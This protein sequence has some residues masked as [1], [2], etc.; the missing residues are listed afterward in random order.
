MIGTGSRKGTWW[1]P[2]NTYTTLKSSVNYYTEIKRKISLSSIE[3]LTVSTDALSGEFV[4]H[5]PTEYDYLYSSSRRKEIITHIQLYY[6]TSKSASLP[7]YGVPQPHL[8]DYRTT[9]SDRKKGLSKIPSKAFLITNFG[10]YESSDSP[11]IS[12]QSIEKDMKA[13]QIKDAAIKLDNFNVLKLLGKGSFGY[14]NYQ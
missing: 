14:S 2:A 13:F 5:V 11:N 12:V 7:I 8:K 1:L 9:S 10:I 4:I 3:C 6:S